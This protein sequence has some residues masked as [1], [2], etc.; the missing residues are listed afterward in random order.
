MR[1]I[2]RVLVCAA[3]VLLA[4]LVAGHVFMIGS[5][6]PDWQSMLNYGLPHG[7]LASV[8]GA[9]AIYVNSLPIVLFLLVVGLAESF[10]LRSLAFYIACGLALTLFLEYDFASRFWP[11]Q[12]LGLTEPSGQILLAMGI[13]IGLVYWSIAGRNAGK[14]RADQP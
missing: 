11:Q 7:S 4:L 8:L 6:A 2:T 1:K 10:A 9:V 5:Y 3:G 14:W 12:P 13:A